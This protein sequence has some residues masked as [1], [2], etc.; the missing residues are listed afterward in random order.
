MGDELVPFVEALSLCDG[1]GDPPESHGRER[2]A[3]GVSGVSDVLRDVRDV[4]RRGLAEGGDVRA[5]A[6]TALELCESHVGVSRDVRDVRELLD[7]V[8][9]HFGLCVASPTRGGKSYLVRALAREMLDQE[10]VCKVYVFSGTVQGA[11]E[12]YAG[13]GALCYEF[14]DERLEKFNRTRQGKSDDVLVIL[15]DVLGTDA[16]TSRAVR[17]LFSEGR[18]LRASC[19]MLSQVANRVLTP[20]VK[21][22]SR[23]IVFGDL[24]DR[25]LKMIYDE[26][27]IRP[28]TTF[29]QFCVWVDEHLQKHTFGVWDAETKR[30]CAVRA[31][32]MTTEA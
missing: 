6:R 18:H 10:R 5:S 13:L 28:A 30:V 27:K 21:Q 14:S 29:R 26:V 19:F 16:G 2:S 31:P 25:Q 1:S 15:D 24:N 17:A 12:S 22:Q 20:L 7:G 8:R 9:G 32:A 11:V 23:F 4:L 3:S